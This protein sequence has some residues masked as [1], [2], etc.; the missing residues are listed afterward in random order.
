[1]W[2]SL[3]QKIPQI[4][5]FRSFFD[6]WGLKTCLAPE[7]DKKVDSIKWSLS[8]EESSDRIQM[9]ANVRLW[10]IKSTL[11][12]VPDAK[13]VFRPQ[14]LKNDRKAKLRGMF[15]WASLMW[16]VCQRL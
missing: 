15:F 6:F 3:A 5:A 11:L 12:T 4:F 14:K 13:H 1:M 9:Y 10:G 8:F 7:T 16:I 2:I